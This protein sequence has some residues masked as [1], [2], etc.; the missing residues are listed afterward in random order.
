MGLASAMST[1]LT[2]LTAAETTIDVVGNNLANSNTVGFKASEAA[3]A[4]LATLL[5][6]IGLYGVLAYAVAQRTR[7]IGL[8]MALGARGAKVR[9]IIL[10]QVGKMM[11]VGGIIG[12]FA[13]VAMGRYAQALLFEMTGNDPLVVAVAVVVLTGVA[14]G[15]GYLPALRASKVDPMKALRYE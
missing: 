5:A 8:R 6:A 15:A 4:T 1:A 12:V 2:G 14:L 11:L 10:W 13:A 9:G 3:F 7:E